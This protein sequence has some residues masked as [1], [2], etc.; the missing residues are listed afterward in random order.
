M[1][2]IDSLFKRFKIAVPLLLLLLC[3][4]AGTGS[5]LLKGQD[6]IRASGGTDLSIDNVSTETFTA[7]SGPTIRETESGQL[8]ANGTIRLTLPSGYTWNTA[9][10]AGDI[11]VL[12]EP[13]GANNTGLEVSFTSISSS[14]VVF[15]VTNESETKGKGQ[16]PGRVT[17]N[18][19]ELRPT[20]TDVPNTGQITNTGTTGPTGLNYGNLSTVSGSVDA[21]R[22]ETA[23]D[24]S[25]QVVPDQSIVAGQSLQV[26]SIARD[27]GGNFI[28]NIELELESDWALTGITGSIQSSALDAANNLRSATFS[29]TRTGSARIRASYSGANLTESGTITVLPR[30][31]STMEIQTQPSS[32][33]TAGSVFSTQPQIRFKDSYGNIVTNDNSTQV[34]VSIASGSGTLLGQ[35][36]QTASNGIVTFDD[37]Q[38]NQ[39]GTVTLHFQ[40]S[41]FNTLTSSTITISPAAASK[42]LWLEQPTNTLPGETISPA[43]ELQLLDAYNNL[44]SQSGVQV[45]MDEEPDTETFLT[46]TTTVSTNSNGV[47]IFNTVEIVNDNSLS[48]EESPVQVQV[49]FSGIS[50]PAVSNNF[51]ILS[52]G[53]LIGFEI[54]AAGGGSIGTQE[55]GVPFDIDIRALDGE[56]NTYT[57]FNGTVELTSD[58]A[59]LQGGGTT[60]SFVNGQLTNHTV[61]LSESGE[62][63]IQAYSAAEDRSGLGNYFTLTPT[64][65]SADESTL[66]VV[67]SELTADGESTT[68][69]TVEI[70]DTY[71]N[72]VGVGGETVELA[73]TAG[74]LT[75]GAQEDQL[76]VLAVDQEDGTYTAT[77]TSS[78]TIESA[79]LQAW[80]GEETNN[81]ELIDELVVEFVAG[82]LDAFV[83]TIPMNGET[84]VTQ[85]AGNS[86]DL[87]VEAVDANGNRT[88][89]FTGDIIFSSD[90]EIS[91]GETAMI[92]NGYLENHSITLTQSGTEV[93]VT[94]TL[95]DLLQTSGTSVSFPVIA[96]DPSTTTSTVVAT[97]SLIQNDGTMQS[98]I[99]ITVRDEFENRVLT[100]LSPDVTLQSEQTEQNGTPGSGTPV[101]TIGSLSFHSGTSTYRSMVTS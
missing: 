92:E 4:S 51:Y 45:T 42:L 100:D 36:T 66:S 67:Q 5:G 80:L 62:I 88:S 61:S 25:G 29:P 34:T 70:L 15:T 94:A 11:S 44:V 13:V 72:A 48:D 82:G 87:S 53:S 71:G 6:V 84:P 35:T 98:T 10:Q 40:S 77:L 83:V 2:R 60:P 1:N 47:A 21:V 7:I 9:L 3:L 65:V 22:V 17:I 50:S 56:E 101:A 79:T 90:S 46:G 30:P 27:A 75:A 57:D 93:T 31:A 89:S 86:F 59:F 63:R 73:T 26:F 23:S 96:S 95:D 74:T 12:I 41:G 20:S 32:S 91:A 54:T 99:I 14:E 52:T 81:G 38:I 64:D 58:S 28:E 97:P 19:L 85:T 68:Q 69:V 18:G 33:A 37:L 8:A 24:G 55:A 76:R 43:M 49:Q 39:A 16:G 78:D